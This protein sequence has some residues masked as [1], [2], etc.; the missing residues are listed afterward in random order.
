MT[1]TLFLENRLWGI[2]NH[3][4]ENI[5]QP[6]YDEVLILVFKN[7]NLFEYIDTKKIRVFIKNIIIEYENSDEIIFLVQYKNEYFLLKYLENYFTGKSGLLNIF[8]EFESLEYF[9]LSYYIKE[10]DNTNDDKDFVNIGK[11]YEDI[12]HIGEGF[13]KIKIINVYKILKPINEDGD[14]EWEYTFDNVTWLILNFNGKK[15]SDFFFK[16]VE[17]FF[18]NVCKVRKGNKWNFINKE[19]N[20]ILNRWYYILNYPILNESVF[21]AGHKTYLIYI[22]Q[23]GYPT[24]CRTTD[25]KTEEEL[26]GQRNQFYYESNSL[27]NKIDNADFTETEIEIFIKKIF[28]DKSKEISVYEII[29]QDL[30]DSYGLVKRLGID[31][32]ERLSDNL[33]IAIINSDFYISTDKFGKDKIIRHIETTIDNMWGFSFSFQQKRLLD[34]NGDFVDNN[35]FHEIHPFNENGIAKVSKTYFVVESD[36]EINYLDT[37]LNENTFSGQISYWKN[38]MNRTVVK[39]IKYSYIDITGKV[40]KDFIDEKDY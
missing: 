11:F 10:I 18:G 32:L 31:S 4:N 19:G 24:I 16:E 15:I 22:F 34:R 5:L 20:F 33:F 36:N 14:L 8:R 37:S 38:D 27:L 2:K 1:L 29:K 6:I 9:Q 12:V 28:D 40:I 39:K 26:V 25:F 35:Y 17:T 7:D 30:Y 3:N 23:N 13:F 21:L